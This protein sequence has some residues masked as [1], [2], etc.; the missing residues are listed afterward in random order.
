[1]SVAPAP[2]NLQNRLLSSSAT[3]PAATLYKPDG[4]GTNTYIKLADGDD[5]ALA[6][7]ISLTG[8]TGAGQFLGIE[9][10]GQT[11]LATTDGT[12]IAE[13]AKVF[14]SAVAGHGGQV[15]AVSSG[16]QIGIALAA[17]AGG[18]VVMQ[19]I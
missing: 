15:S 1:M 18:T 4:G 9:Y 17:A 19:W 16:R 8:V 7:G 12:A 2:G 5:G 10:R 3:I 11:V 6:V 13:G 14:A